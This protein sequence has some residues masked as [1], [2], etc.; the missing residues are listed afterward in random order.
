[1]S[2][3]PGAFRFE[4]VCEA[5]APDGTRT[6]LGSYGIPDLCLL[7]SGPV[8]VDDWSTGTADCAGSVMV[9]HNN[10]PGLMCAACVSRHRRQGA[11]T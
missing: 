1:M 3:D 5:V 9:T 8:I 4:M 7:C 6:R 11:A 2:V 10:Q